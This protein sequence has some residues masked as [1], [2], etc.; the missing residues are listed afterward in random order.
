MA[1]Y[2]F[3]NDFL[4]KDIQEITEEQA[5]LLRGQYQWIIG[6]DSFEVCPEV[7]WKYDGKEFYRDVKPV[8]PRQFRQAAILMGI[9]LQMIEEAIEQLPDPHKSLAKVEWEYSTLF[10]RRRPI[11]RMMGTILGWTEKQID[12]LWVVA[13]KIE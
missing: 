5:G 12:D 2:L 8:T 9:S 1:K 7:G 6:I 10:E 11:V 4:V 3:V 13:G